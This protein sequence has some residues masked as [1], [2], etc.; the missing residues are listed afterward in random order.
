M[1]KVNGGLLFAKALKNEGVECV[2]ALC[3]GHIMPIFYGLREVGIEIIDFRHECDAAYAADAYAQVTGK[4]GVVLTTAGPGIS[5]TVTAMLESMH[6]G[7]PVVHIGGA[8]PVKEN[9]TGPLQ[10]M[11]TLQVLADC[12]KWARKIYTTQR[13]PEYVGMAFRH[14]LDDFPGPVYLECATDIVGAFVEEDDVVF[15][16]NYRTDAQPFGDPSLIDKAADLLINAQSPAVILGAGARYSIQYGEEAIPELVDYLK[17]PVGCQEMTRG[18]VADESKN[19]QFKMMGAVPGADVV[20][21]LGVHFNYRMA[22]GKA[23]LF[24]PDVKIIQVHTDKTK[25]GYNAPAEIGIVGGAGAVAKQLLEA[26]KAKTAKKED[27]TWLKKAGE[28]VKTVA[29]PWIQGLMAEGNPIHPGRCAGEVGKFLAT[30]G[31]DWTVIADGGDAAQWIKAAVS[32]RRNNQV[33]CYGPNGTIG[34]GAGFTIGAWAANRKPVLW[35]TGDGS[36]G[37]Y[38]MELDTMARLGIPV[39]VVISNDSA[40]GMIKLSEGIAREDI[41]KEKGHCNVD[42]H[43][44]RAYEKL[45]EVW[46]GYGELVTEADQIVPAIQRAVANGKPSIIN[47]EVDKENM[48]PITK[49]FSESMKQGMKSSY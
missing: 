11:P 38:T 35:Y 6:H 47:V 17:L 13:I 31:Q 19:P 42:L 3:G 9:D 10:D 29:T 21:A 45:P 32:A 2:F 40:W 39:V 26:V 20:L 16:V 24:R 7:N 1:A 43:H 44:M 25:I 14:A 4:P 48:S 37:F 22:K 34:V 8:S 27:L 46:G 41:I 5:D 15:P 36:F 33:I 49:G 23:P 28:I 30:E 12:T 18:L